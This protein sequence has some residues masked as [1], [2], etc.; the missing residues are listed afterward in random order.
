MIYIIIKRFTDI[1]ISILILITSSPIIIFFLLQVYL[2]DKSSP[3]Y[4][5]NR[6]GLK[7]KNFNMIKIRSMIVNAEK[8]GIDSTSSND[9]RITKLGKT[10]RKYKID[11]LTQLINV[12]IGN[13]SLVG[14]RP[15]VARDVE[16]YS[17]DEKMLLSV[18]PGVTDFSSIIF[19]DEGNILAHQD[20]PDLAYNQ[21]IRPWK[22][23]LGILYIE[24]RSMSLDLSIIIYTGIALISKKTSINW[25]VRKLTQL[26]A[27]PKLIEVCKRDKNLYAHPPPG[28]IKIVEK[29]SKHHKL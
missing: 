22:S 11:E 27:E 7:F 3:I 18:V 8:N 26:K 4:L 19:S 14:P 13:M 25:I 24:N 9:Q 17:D 10:I 28:Q 12:I 2:Q 23:R 20:D 29:R 5:A 6:V 21:L 15:N 1:L 16:L